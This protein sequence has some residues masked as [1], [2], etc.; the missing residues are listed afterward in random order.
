MAEVACTPEEQTGASRI[1][2]DQKLSDGES[3]ALRGPLGPH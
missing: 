3:E 1:S 2:E